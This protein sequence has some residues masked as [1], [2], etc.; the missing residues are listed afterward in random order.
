MTAATPPASPAAPLHRE[1]VQSALEAWSDGA[2]QLLEI[3][4]VL[5][6]GSAAIFVAVMVLVALAVLGPQRIRAALGRHAWVVGGGIVFPTVVL[7]GLL[8]YTLSA[9]GPVSH[10]RGPSAAL[11][12][13]VTG[14]L[15][16]WRVRYLDG[17]G[18]VLLE[19]ANEIHIPAGQPV[20]LALVS[21]NVI[22]SFWVPNLA[23]KLDMIPGHVNWLRIEAREPGVYRGQC[24]EYCGAQH[25][26]M[27]FHVV[28]QPLADFERWLQQQL[29]PAA[30]P[31]EPVLQLGQ[32]LFLENRCG[33]CHTVRGTPADGRLGP[34]LTHV[35]LRDW[36][37][38]GILPN[39]Q[40]TL[41]G[42]IAN[43]QEI[44]AGARMPAYQ[45]FSGDE[46]RALSA[47]LASL[48]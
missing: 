35:G 34:E 38:A 27:A 2:A 24:A 8:V 15:W 22:H 13:E 21:D 48:R 29:R 16:W 33:V 12:I 46:L 1:G 5:L 44:K 47:W 6:I 43:P 23:G 4:W 3:T 9:A 30:P 10:P 40:G 14:E 39:N 28:A 36:V 17:Q 7:T 25:A 20:D 19:T 41:A 31:Q 37:A 42:W 32:R 45:R 26:K 18:G 11:R